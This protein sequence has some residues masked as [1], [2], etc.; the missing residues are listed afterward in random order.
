LL[1]RAAEELELDLDA[2]WT[3]GDSDSDVE[4]GRRAGT[5]TVLVAHPGS[6]HRRTG[7]A[8]ADREAAD[9]DEAAGRILGLR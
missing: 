4:A 9:L 1:L 3:V 8:V 7:T 2:S 6:A 5:R